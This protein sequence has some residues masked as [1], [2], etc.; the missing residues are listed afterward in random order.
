MKHRAEAE[1]ESGTVE[2][3]RIS[4]L[5]L[6]HIGD[7]IGQRAIVAKAS[8]EDERN[9]GFNALVH[10][11]A[12]EA[13]AFDGL[14]NIACPVDGIDGTHVI[15]VAMFFLAAIGSANTERCAVKGGFDVVNSQRISGKDGIDPTGAHEFRKGRNAAG[16]NHYGARNGDD[17]FAFFACELHHGNGLLNGR[18]NLPFGRDF[19]AHEGERL[20]ISFFRFG[21]DANAFHPDDDS[22]TRFDIAKATAVGLRSGYDNHAVHSLIMNFQP[23]AFVAHEGALVSG[24]VEVFGCAAVAFGCLQFCVSAINRSTAETEQLGE[25]L[26]HLLVIWCFE[27][28]AEERGVAVG[29][30]DRKVLDF[31]AAAKFDNGVEDALHDVRVDEMTLGLDDFRDGELTHKTV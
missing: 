6:I 30:P 4:I 25:H 8:R 31:E 13:S 12:F 27:P 2:L 21:D 18:F 29:A 3:K 20:T 9:T 5:R 15:A 22:I 10:E 17:A 26:L 16:M 24:R 7:A 11:T 19:V 1:Y 28:Q 23:L 14:A